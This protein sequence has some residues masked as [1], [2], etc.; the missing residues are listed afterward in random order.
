M[1]LNRAL[2]RQVLVEL[3]VERPTHVLRQHFPDERHERRTQAIDSQ[4]PRHPEPVEPGE[5]E[6]AQHDIR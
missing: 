6:V 3:D 1:S 5:I 4:G 2:E